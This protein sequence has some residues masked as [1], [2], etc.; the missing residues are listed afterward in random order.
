MPGVHKSVPDP[1]HINELSKWSALNL[2][3][4]I[5]RWTKPSPKSTLLIDR[6]E[7]RNLNYYPFPVTTNMSIGNMLW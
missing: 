5:A 3:Q 2:G 4:Y 6:R 1:G 7:I